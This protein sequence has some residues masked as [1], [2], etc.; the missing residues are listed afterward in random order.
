M[1]QLTG[2]RALR[3]LPFNG[4]IIDNGT[5]SGAVSV[6]SGKVISGNGSVGALTVNSAATLSPGNSP[7]HAH[8]GQRHLSRRRQFQARAD[9]ATNPVAGT[10]NDLLTVT[11]GLDLSSLSS[12]TTV[13]AETS[14]PRQQQRHGGTGRL[15][16]RPELLVD[17]GHR[18]Q[19]HQPSGRI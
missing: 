1:P 13:R 17:V 6:H 10:N 8:R 14:N 18:R 7:R 12:G 5:I 16:P 3:R 11:N 2:E 4:N 19:F 15:Q 9:L